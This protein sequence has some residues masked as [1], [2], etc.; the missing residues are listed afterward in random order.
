MG[1]AFLNPFDTTLPV[2]TNLANN[3]DGYILDGTKKSLDERYSLEHESLNSGANDDTI[4]GGQGRHIPGKV[5]C[6][7]MGT[8]AE[9]LAVVA[10][11][12]GAVWLD[13][14]DDI[15]YRYDL[16]G[17]GGWLDPQFGT[18]TAYATPAEVE[19]GLVEKAI[20]TET[21][22]QADWEYVDI[23]SHTAYGITQNTSFGKNDKNWEVAGFQNTGGTV[24]P[25]EI[26]LL[27]VLVTCK[28]TTGGTA[29]V[30]ASYP[31]TLSDKVLLKNNNN[32]A[33]VE[34]IVDQ[35]AT[36]PVNSDTTF[37]NIIADIITNG[38]AQYTIIGAT[39][40]TWAE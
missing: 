23:N 18:G 31:G 7:G 2:G 25:S 33:V 16:S 13:T 39:Q 40:R 26:R 1:D 34:T 20:S 17:G 36:I 35:V 5:G 29:S 21:L 11:G 37:V 8:T 4:A 6:F 30:V 14:D 24:V 19:A 28:V 22:R 12:D 9:R 10:P 27:H 3:I 38:F 15:F 32:F